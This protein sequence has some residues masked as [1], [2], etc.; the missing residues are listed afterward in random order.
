M[1]PSRR[2]FQSLIRL[3]GAGLMLSA[4]SARAQEPELVVKAFPEV[5]FEARK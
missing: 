5:V 4:A 3:A 1:G 2:R